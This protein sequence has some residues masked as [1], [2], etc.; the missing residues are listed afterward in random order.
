VISDHASA[1]TLESVDPATGEVLATLPNCGPDEVDAAVRAAR[2]AQA[3]WAAG[4][5]MERSACSCGSPR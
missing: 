5:P 4:D 1:S 2:S 3:D